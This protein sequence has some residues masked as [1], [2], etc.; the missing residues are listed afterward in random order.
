MDSGSCT[1]MMTTC[2]YAIAVRKSVSS[3]NFILIFVAFQQG[4]LFIFLPFSFEHQ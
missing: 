2:K 1:Q 4:V 3:E